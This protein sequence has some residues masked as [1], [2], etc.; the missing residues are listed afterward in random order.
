MID[1]G[2][3]WGSCSLESRLTRMADACGVDG[4]LE[5]QICFEPHDQPTGV[6]L[7]LGDGAPLC[8]NERK[9][10]RLPLEK[11]VDA[12]LATSVG[13]RF[14]IM[15]PAG[16]RSRQDDL[17]GQIGAVVHQELSRYARYV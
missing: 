7:L 8:P 2:G 12:S 9:G 16:T 15:V 10:R 17:Y 6:F 11:D 14:I 3:R 4:P 5:L 1:G 13:R